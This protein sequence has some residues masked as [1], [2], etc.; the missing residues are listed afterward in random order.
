M[1]IIHTYTAEG[2]STQTWEECGPVIKKCFSICYEDLTKPECVLCAG[3]AD[4]YFKCTKCFYRL[5]EVVSEQEGKIK[6]SIL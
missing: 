5:Q 4:I 1:I 6:M 2:C 3:Q